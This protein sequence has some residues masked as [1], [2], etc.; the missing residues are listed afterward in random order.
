MG[1]QSI[2]NSAT[3][4]CAMSL[5]LAIASG[6]R[7]G[8]GERNFAWCAR[9]SLISRFCRHRTYRLRVR[10]DGA[11]KHRCH[12]VVVLSSLQ[13]TELE[14]KVSEGSHGGGGK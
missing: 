9:H 11:R 4:S 10:S 8:V 1:F 6:S 13:V 7:F 2:S 14:S 12:E 3:S 5:V